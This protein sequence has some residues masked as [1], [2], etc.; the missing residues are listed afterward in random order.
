MPNIL[1]IGGSSLVGKGLI[2][3]YNT[4][5]LIKKYK[6]Y[7]TAR[8]KVKIPLQKEFIHKLDI[9]NQE[10]LKKIYYD[11]KPEIIIFIAS[12]GRID[13]CEKNKEKAKNINIDALNNFID[14]IENYNTHF[15]YIS[16]NAVFDGNSAPYNEND[17]PNPVNYY[18]WTKFEAETI[19]NKRLHNKYTIVRPNLLIGLSYNG[20]RQS[21]IEYF[22]TRLLKKKKVTVVD[23]IYNNPLHTNYLAEGIF[24][25]IENPNVSKNEIFHFGGKASLSRYEL[26]IK[27]CDYFELDSNLVGKANSS[28]FPYLTIRM[29]DTTYNTVKAEKILGWESPTLIQSYELLKAELKNI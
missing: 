4:N 29:P 18:G 26:I 14:I 27:L 7:I 28:A 3:Y 23:D 20:R 10:E 25:I 17:H 11:I 24:K 16:S 19:V 1:I 12:E 22:L 5:I 2:N 6:L 15:I 21:A 13:Y 8:G 9:L